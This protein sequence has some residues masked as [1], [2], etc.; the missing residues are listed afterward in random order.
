MYNYTI[1]LVETILSAVT[2]LV[3]LYFQHSDRVLQARVIDILLSVIFATYWIVNSLKVIKEN[4]E[5][6]IDLPI[7]EADQLLILKI[8][9]APC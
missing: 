2:L 4:F 1:C 5:A 8:L 7:K 6:L 3:A 9:A